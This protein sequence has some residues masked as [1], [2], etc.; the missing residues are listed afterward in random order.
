MSF[1]PADRPVTARRVVDLRNYEPLH[2]PVEWL[3][4][5]ASGLEE[6]LTAAI[7]IGSIT[8]PRTVEPI[9][10]SVPPGDDLHIVRVSDIEDSTYYDAPKLADFIWKRYKTGD[11]KYGGWSF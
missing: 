9:M 7:N 3:S 10:R 6:A 11:L 8:V 4:L 1:P 5:H 2:N